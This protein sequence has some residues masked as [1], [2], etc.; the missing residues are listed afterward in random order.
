MDLPIGPWLGTRGIYLGFAGHNFG[1][2]SLDEN[3]LANTK[4]TM[5]TIV[6]NNSFRKLTIIG[7]SVQARLIQSMKMG[8]NFGLGPGPLAQTD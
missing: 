1:V 2:G 4:L 6:L 7:I 5:S 3:Y 8:F